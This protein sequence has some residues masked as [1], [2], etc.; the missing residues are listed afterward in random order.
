MY[1]YILVLIAIVFL[2]GACKEDDTISLNESVLFKFINEAQDSFEDVK[3][4]AGANSNDSD[5]IKKDSIVFNIPS[6][7]IVPVEWKPKVPKGDG[8][9][10][11]KFTGERHD[12]FGYFTNGDLSG[13]NI[14]E[15]TIKMI[16]L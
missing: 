7:D 5:F 3:L 2:I 9:F 13:G 1:K 16:Q 12:Y 11:I 6:N 15:V 4:Y 14:F 10:L 8:S